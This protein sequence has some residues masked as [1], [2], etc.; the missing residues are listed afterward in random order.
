VKLPVPPAFIYSEF[1]C[2]DKPLAEQQ[3][4]YEGQSSDTS[5][6]ESLVNC[7]AVDHIAENVDSSATGTHKHVFPQMAQ[8]DEPDVFTEQQQPDDT[9]CG[10]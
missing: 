1:P 5:N 7:Q 2:K 6:S 3:E 9:I 10:E 4:P 8:P